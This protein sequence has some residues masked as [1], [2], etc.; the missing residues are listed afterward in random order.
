MSAQPLATQALATQPT[1]SSTSP[2]SLAEFLRERRGALGLS[3]A[4][5]AR[6]AGC[7]RQYVAQL[8]RAERSRPSPEMVQALA[9]ALALE[10]PARRAFWLVCGQGWEAAPAPSPTPPVS[11]VAARLIDSVPVPALLH[12]GCWRIGYHN[13]VLSRFLSA[14][15]SE[16]RLGRSMLALAFD[17][18]HRPAVPQWEAWARY[19]L[20]QFKRDSAALSGTAIHAELLRELRALP[21]FRRLWRSTEPADE[22][23]PLMPLHYQL[24]GAPALA[25]TVSRWQF[26]ETP[27]L[28]G[29]V[30]LPENEGAREFVA[31]AA[32]EGGTG[33][34]DAGVG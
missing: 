7:T 18:W 17:P 4:A 20:A 8:E 30:F 6:Q 15:G 28:W 3:Q 22:R 23:T 27:D 26:V 13:A 29:V 19:L 1:L 2:A 12:D 25:F 5:V 21:D 31:W 10:G 16:T 24:P 33:R 9:R 11:E 34:T 14:L 32:G